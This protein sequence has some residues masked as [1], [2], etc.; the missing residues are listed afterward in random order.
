MKLGGMPKDAIL[1]RAAGS[2]ICKRRRPSSRRQRAITVI[3]SPDWLPKG[4][5]TELRTRETGVSAG[6]TDKYFFDPVSDHRFRSKKDVFKFLQTG[7]INRL[8]S[9]RKTEDHDGKTSAEKKS[10]P[11]HE[12]AGNANT[13]VSSLS[14][15]NFSG[16]Q[17]TAGVGV[18]KRP[19]KVRWVLNSS[20]GSWVP[21]IGEEEMNES[22][23]KEE[24]L[25][26]DLA[27]NY[28]DACSE[29]QLKTAIYE[30]ATPS[31][32]PTK[33]SIEGEIDLNTKRE[34]SPT[35]SPFGDFWRDPCLEFAVKTLTGAIPVV[36]DDLVL[37][38]VLKN[39]FSPQVKTKENLCSNSNL[40]DPLG[41][42]AL[43]DGSG[44]NKH[45]EHPTSTEER[46]SSSMVEFDGSNKNQHT[47]SVS[48]GFPGTRTLNRYGYMR[49][50]K[51]F[52][53]Q[54]A[55]DLLEPLG[56]KL[57]KQALAFVK[58]SR[59]SNM[60][61]EKQEK[62]MPVSFCLSQKFQIDC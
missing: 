1:S 21:F 52:I 15:Q 20:E 25:I 34:D 18:S 46:A 24:D 26:F 9:K 7:N 45:A 56:R 8:G 27:G 22:N 29:E 41:S 11:G 39:Y 10:S 31:K 23:L 30:N 12:A 61:F 28:A 47:S 40:S 38:D 33:E 62:A 48:D 19:T 4:W 55:K 17:N 32:G 5:I 13:P 3:E 43:V 37:Q 6:T 35:V 53:R 44:S 49:K 2:G 14:S 54:D 57:C 59:H 36:D 42:V 51:K 60:F 58:E 50:M 16:L